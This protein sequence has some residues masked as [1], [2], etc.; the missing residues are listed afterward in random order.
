MNKYVLS[1]SGDFS[2]ACLLSMANA[3][4][5]IRGSHFFVTKSGQL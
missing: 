4:P 2:R 1:P 5:N 3:E